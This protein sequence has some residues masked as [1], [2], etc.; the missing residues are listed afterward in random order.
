MPL[1]HILGEPI[2]QVVEN[3]LHSAPAS[4]PAIAD[5]RSGWPGSAP[6]PPVLG[7]GRRH[8]QR[9]HPVTIFLPS[10]PHPIP[11]AADHGTTMEW[12]LRCSRLHQSL[13]T[14]LCAAD[15]AAPHWDI[16]LVEEDRRRGVGAGALDEGMRVRHALAGLHSG[17][18]YGSGTLGNR[19]Q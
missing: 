16:G 2:I 12:K 18:R 4:R 5:R 3:S 6:T 11:V 10:Y 15:V 19:H 1:L 14:A 7:A 13:S 9:S 17:V 8:I